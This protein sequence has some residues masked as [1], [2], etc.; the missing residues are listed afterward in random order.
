M[1]GRTCS[2]GHWSGCS[3]G[4]RLSGST[5]P[6]RKSPAA[7]ASPDAATTHSAVRHGSG[8]YR[9]VRAERAARASP[10]SAAATPR[11]SV[12]APSAAAVV[13]SRSPYTPTHTPQSPRSTSAPLMILR[14]ALV[15]VVRPC[16]RASIAAASRI[17]RSSASVIT[18][19]TTWRRTWRREAGPPPRSA[20]AR[21]T[22]R[23]LSTSCGATVS[24][25]VTATPISCKDAGVDF[26]R[27]LGFASTFAAP[28]QRISVA[29]RSPS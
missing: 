28:M 13:A 8:R 16:P 29:R 1:S 7:T 22:R 20:R 11:T 14:G 3:D 2:V 27:R 26:N 23:A 17:E 9:V 10:P 25:T 24:A 19:T 21:R 4:L 5:C 18:G 6:A 12:G 15:S